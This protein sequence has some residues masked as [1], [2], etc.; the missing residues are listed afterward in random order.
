MPAI[1][2][3]YKAEFEDDVNKA[4]ARALETVGGTAERHA[5]DI[6]PVDTGRLRN[7]IAHEPVG[8][9]TES[10]GTDVEYA[11][12]VELGTRYQSPQPYLRPGVENYA[13]EYAGI[14]KNELSKV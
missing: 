4:I 9:N 10:I 1:F 3:S 14:I 5:K 6:C 8:D 12:Y 7:S 11:P 13:E 2:T